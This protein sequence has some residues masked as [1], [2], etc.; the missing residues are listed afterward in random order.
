MKPLLLAAAVLLFAPAAQAQVAAGA[1]PNTFDGPTM[2]VQAVQPVSPAPAAAPLNPGAEDALRTII[3][4]A[5]AG[6]ID[7]GL[8]TDDLAEKVREQEAVVTPLIQRFGVVVAVD[9]MGSQ[10]GMDGFAVTF[11]EAVT[12]W[13]IA[14]ND[15]GKITGLLFRPAE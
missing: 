1:V 6:A 11:A 2:P 4:G 12:E 9:F 10:E 8:M 7:Y 14:L 5:Q 13:M 15:E 3:A